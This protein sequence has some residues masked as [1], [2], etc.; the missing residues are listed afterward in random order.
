ML[1][2]VA[3]ASVLEA[4]EIRHGHRPGQVDQGRE[5]VLS[6][7]VSGHHESGCPEVAALDPQRAATSSE[8]QL[9]HG[10]DVHVQDPEL[11]FLLRRD[12]D[13]VCCCDVETANLKRC[14]VKILHN[15]G[16]SCRMWM[17][18]FTYPGV[19]CVDVVQKVDVLHFRSCYVL[20]R[21]R[22]DPLSDLLLLSNSS[23]DRSL[24][25]QPSGTNVTVIYHIEYIDPAYIATIYH[26][27]Y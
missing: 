13:Q 11:L 8:W 14:F 17:E 5:D 12:K 19:S 3:F 24:S 15:G 21:A 16:L 27:I 20:H 6:V 23:S 7:S 22:G 4:V 2:K 10:A 25:Q 1:G 9:L 18:V 26:N